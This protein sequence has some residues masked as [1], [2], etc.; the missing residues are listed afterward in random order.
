MGFDPTRRHRRSA[1]DY[2]YVG[3]GVVVFIGLVL[4]A[5]VG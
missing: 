4:W 1:F 3:A 2:W 5:L